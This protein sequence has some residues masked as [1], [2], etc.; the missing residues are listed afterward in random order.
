MA[1][2][3]FYKCGEQATLNGQLVL[4]AEFTESTHPGVSPPEIL[5]PL[6]SPP[7][8]LELSSKRGVY[9]PRMAGPARVS[10]SSFCAMRD[11]T[12]QAHDN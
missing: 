10:G 4:K 9:S 1:P 8:L 2:P 12:N 11:R 3:G 5:C 7:P 6:H